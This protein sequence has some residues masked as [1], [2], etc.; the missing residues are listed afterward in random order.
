[1][2]QE[3]GVTVLWLTSA[4][5]H[6]MV[7]EQ[8]DSLR[9]VRQLLAG[10]DV[11]SVPHVLR[12]ARELPDC[13]MVNGY[14]PTENTTFTTTHWIQ[15]H[16]QGMQSVPIGRPIANTRVYVLDNRM[17]PV[18][19]GVPGELFIAGDGLARG[20]LRRPE[21]TAEKFVRNPLACEPGDRLYRTGDLARYRE[22]GCI[23]FLG[24]IDQ[25]VKIRGFR[26]E[27]GEIEAALRAHP[28]VKECAVVPREDAP[29]ARRLVAY[30]APDTAYAGAT[31]GDSDQAQVDQWQLVFDESLGPDAAAGDPTFNASGWT[32]SYTRLPIPEIEMREQ[33]GQTADRILA[34]NPRRV[35]EI[36]CGTGLLLFR[37]APGC[38]RYVATDLSPVILDYVRDYAKRRNLDQVEFLERAADNFEGL[39]PGSFDAVVLNS[40]VQYFPNLEYLMRVIEGALRMVRPGGYVFLGDIRNLA[41]LEAFRTSVETFRAEPTQLIRDLRARVLSQIRQERELLID[42]LFFRELP[43]HLPSLD[44]AYLRVKH[45]AHQNE[46]TL[47]RYDVVLQARGG[48]AAGPAVQ[49]IDWNEAGSLDA[50]ASLLA[51]REEDIGIRGIPSQ[52][53]R[54]PLRTAELLAAASGADTAAG[55]LSAIDAL[56]EDAGVD[57]EALWALAAEHSCDAYIGW[58]GSGASACYDVLFRGRDAARLPGLPLNPSAQ[59]RPLSALVNNPLAC[60]F[61]HRIVPELRGFLRERLP[62]FMIPA[63]FVVLDALPVNANGK[64]DRRA[65]P[66][67]EEMR[68]EGPEES[69]AT[70]TGT[71]QAIA[72]IWM[73][74]LGLASVGVEDNF[75]DL[76]GHSLL[77]T[78]VVSRIR[79][80][81]GLELPLRRLFESPTVAGLARAVEECR[82]K[83]TPGASVPAVSIRAGGLD[84]D[85]LSD[86]DVDLLLRGMLSEGDGR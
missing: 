37:V 34:L 73:Q 48:A 14:G 18:P 19:V 71:E 77:A 3:N 86:A 56:E 23:Q 80:Q 31:T 30:V 57:P 17:N 5:F 39:E 68:P 51:A 83:Q 8:I 22:D 85:R 64:V 24:R 7:D 60:A 54:T 2:I 81:F 41:L 61:A 69:A 10:G 43:R 12:V 78:Q 75:F 82:E 4:L 66:A 52:P 53:L 76:G 58:T 45:G 29:G 21:L 67:P 26:I 32:S 6:Q 74:V 35:L 42:P 16:D 27:P 50:V 63:A 9:G 84:V 1:V 79:S 36:G 47:F 13:R 25:Q 70:R 49:W 72:D 40:V 20:Y 33:V 65:L 11:L 46:V 44:G 28:G 62:E 38:S 15:P 55:L 59:P